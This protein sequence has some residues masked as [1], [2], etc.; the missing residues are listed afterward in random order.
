MHHPRPY[1]PLPPTMSPASYSREWHPH[2]RQRPNRQLA[3]VG[4]MSSLSRRACYKCGNVGHYAGWSRRICSRSSYLLILL[5]KFAHHR[6]ACAIIVCLFVLRFSSGVADSL[7]RQASSQV[8]STYPRSGRLSNLAD[9]DN[10]TRIEWLST[11]TY[12]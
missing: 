7:V 5:Q 8:E 3:E 1:Q 2:T 6:S 9:D 10:R 12:H 11:S 4:E